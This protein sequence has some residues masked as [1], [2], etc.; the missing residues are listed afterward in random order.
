MA[1][2]VWPEYR[3][4]QSRSSYFNFGNSLTL[5]SW[6][7]C[8]QLA[9][10]GILALVGFHRDGQKDKTPRGRWIW[11]GGA[12]VALTLSFAEMTRIH[13][14]LRLLGYP[15]LD[16]YELLIYF[17]LYSGLLGLLG[18]FLLHRLQQVPEF[19]RY[20][21]GWLIAWGTQLLFSLL[22]QLRWWPEGWELGVSLATGLAYLF[23]CTFLLLALAGCV[24][25]SRKTDETEATPPEQED[26]SYPQGLGRIWIYVG[27]AG[28]TFTIIFL[29][30]MLLRMMTIFGDYLTAQSVISIALLGISAGGLIGSFASDRAPLRAMIGASLFLPVSVLVAFGASVSL[31]DTP[32]TASILL[33]L[34]FVAASTVITVALCRARS[35]LIYFIDLLGGALGALFVSTAFAYFREESGLLFLSAFTFLL[36][37]CFI[38][39]YPGRGARRWLGVLA[40]MGCSSLLILGIMNLEKDWLN[41]VRTKVQKRYPRANVMFSRSTFVGRYDVIRRRP[42]NSSMSAYENGRITDTLRKR[43]AE[44]YQIDPRVPHTLMDDPR[45]LILGLSGDGISKTAKT[46]GSEVVGVEINPAIVDLQTTELVPFNGNSYEGLDVVIMDG[47]SLVEQSD[48]SYDMITLM[49]AHLARGRTAGRSPSPEYLDTREAIQSYLRLLTDR[50]VLNV[51]EPVSRPRREPPVWKLVGT[52]RQALLDQGSSQPERHFFIFQW[53]TSSNNYIQILMKKTPFSDED[54]VNLKRWLDDVDNIRAIEAAQGKRMGPIRCKTT[55]LHVPGEPYNTNYSR[56]LRGEVDESFLA[57]RNLVVTTDD[58]PFHFDVDPAHPELKEAYRRTLLMLL[59][60]SP[61]FLFMLRRYRGELGNAL[62]YLLAVSLTGI[63]YFLIEVVL[64]QRYEI[65]LGSPVVTFSTVLGT[66][67][68]ASGLGSLWSGR[69]GHRRV[70]G[71]VGATLVLLMLHQ[72]WIPSLF[73]WGAALSLSGKVVLSVLTLAPLAFFMGVPF[74][75][76][77]RTSKTRFT[78][79]AA[80]LLFAVNGAASALAVP[81]ALNL[82]T[83]WGLS[84]IFQLSMVIYLVVG[85]SMLGTHRREILT[86]ANG[87]TVLILI[88]ILASPWLMSLPALDVEA[89]SAPYSLYGVSY[90]RSTY[91]ENRVVR[92][93][94][95]SERVPFEWLFWV[96]QGRGKTILVDTGFRDAALAQRWGIR[97][98]VPPTQRL[99]QLGIS[100][101]DVSD[102]I[103]THAHWDHMGDLP[104]YTKA[105]I[106]I[107]KSEYEHA[108]SVVTQQDPDGRGMRW[109]DIE[110]LR[111]AEQE[112]RLRLVDGQETLMPGI[113]M[114]LGKSHTPGSQFVEVETIDGTVVVAG[115]VTYLYR[116]NQW[117]MLVGSA[118]DHDGNLTTIREMHRRAASPFLIL[119]GHDPLVTRWFPEISDGIYQVTSVPE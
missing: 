2:L 6:L 47:R 55:I 111:R 104:P 52:M 57:A 5:A 87:L 77:L 18:W 66:L 42:T 50:G 72:W 28:M 29:Q 102:V 13:D 118:V 58:R 24:L 84:A 100:P 3:W 30:I 20:G 96:I 86:F 36:A 82:S 46:L 109:Q 63:G 35:H 93:G 89:E 105:R 106:W 112:G 71:A 31:M 91:R 19:Y 116:N 45:I 70:Y 60:L 51:E 119:P 8:V 95:R 101:D 33:M 99:A 85:I 7:A 38:I 103:V 26:E 11:L 88:P 25:R 12:L 17:S 43:T 79:S 49:N 114:I 44:Y 97:N 32:L 108:V 117:H 74:P 78:Q 27:V 92:G 40:V 10:V 61:L 113:R 16:P 75:F 76:L 68:I 21:V 67:L 23:G 53:K 15:R 9:A 90:G 69:V 81:L 59:V 34:P 22:T 98:F 73:Q 94:S 14:R 115:D 107:Q 39:I 4:G 80:G 1:H 65:F 48:Q 41:I 37:G 56:I 64:I 54:I 83:T 62:P 110:I